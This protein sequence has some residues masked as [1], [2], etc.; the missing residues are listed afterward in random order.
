MNQTTSVRKK[1]SNVRAFTQ[2]T[3][4]KQAFLHSEEKNKH[5]VKNKQ[6]QRK[7]MKYGACWDKK[8]FHPHFLD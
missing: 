3:K 6:Q 2:Q 8:R 7:R 1:D 5:T 4:Q